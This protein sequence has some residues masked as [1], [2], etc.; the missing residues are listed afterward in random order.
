MSYDG[1][2][3]SA[4]IPITLGMATWNLLIKISVGVW[5]RWKMPH[6]VHVLR[7]TVY[8]KMALTGQCYRKESGSDERMV[9]NVSTS[10]SCMLSPWEIDLARRGPHRPLS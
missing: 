8:G 1:M 2:T 7:L 5:E 9:L 3:T 4:A 6:G 10:S